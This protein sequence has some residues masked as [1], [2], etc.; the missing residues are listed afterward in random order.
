MSA[1]AHEAKWNDLKPVPDGGESESDSRDGAD[2]A[3]GY[4]QKIMDN[5][6][7]TLEDVHIRKHFQLSFSG[8]RNH[9]QPVV[10][11]FLLMFCVFSGGVC[12]FLVS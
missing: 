2:F 5:I 12:V 4:M 1:E 3:S 8:V 7:V 10:L 6:Q 9:F 11:N